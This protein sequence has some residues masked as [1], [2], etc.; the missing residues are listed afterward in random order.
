LKAP[1][2][3]R[4]AEAD[5]QRNDEIADRRFATARELQNPTQSIS[6]HTPFYP[7]SPLCLMQQPPPAVNTTR[8]VPAPHAIR[9][10]VRSCCGDGSRVFVVE[11]PVRGTIAEVKRL[12]CLPPHSDAS[13]L[14]LVLKGE[15]AAVAVCDAF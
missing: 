12:L 6:P 13:A 9:V 1:H 10:A 2:T 5:L 7:S 14:E 4:D 3:K 8:P 11:A 15:G